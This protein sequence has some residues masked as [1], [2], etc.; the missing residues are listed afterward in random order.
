[1]TEKTPASAQISVLK[2]AADLAR[3]AKLERKDPTK[4]WDLL[5]EAVTLA[6]ASWPS[7][8]P[9]LGYWINWTNRTFP[10]NSEVSNFEHEVLQVAHEIEEGTVNG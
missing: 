7:Q 5:A 3:G 6:Q 10:D 4:A 9:K 8:G 1:M 2:R